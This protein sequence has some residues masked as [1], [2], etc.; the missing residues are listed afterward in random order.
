MKPR[1]WLISSRGFRDAVV[2]DSV[3]NH[4]LAILGPQ[5]GQVNEYRAVASILLRKNIKSEKVL[6]H[7]C[8]VVEG[9][10]DSRNCR[11]CQPSRA[12]TLC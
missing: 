4:W 9:F 1:L 2:R 7:Q 3:A 11:I 8:T 6:R 5:V 12:G 10:H